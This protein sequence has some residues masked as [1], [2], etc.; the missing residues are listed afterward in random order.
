MK[1]KS[2]FKET[3]K[4]YTKALRLFKG[5]AIKLVVSYSQSKGGKWHDNDMKPI[6]LGYLKSQE[7]IF[8]AR[9]LVIGKHKF[10]LLVANK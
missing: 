9:A 2:F 1:I 5:K 10:S 3:D 4:Y 7:Y 8:N 6:K